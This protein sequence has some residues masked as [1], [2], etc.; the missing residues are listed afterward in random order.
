MFF[1]RFRINFFISLTLSHSA[2]SFI[3]F[4]FFYIV[5]G[6][7]SRVYT[8]QFWLVIGIYTYEYVRLDFDVAKGHTYTHT[9]TRITKNNNNRERT[10]GP[11]EARIPPRTY[12]Y[13]IDGILQKKNLMLKNRSAKVE[14]KLLQC[15][16]DVIVFIVYTHNQFSFL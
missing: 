5:C 4:F 2:G 16:S 3:V 7:F 10:K 1:K 14:R 13:T 15:R 12:T 8:G 11:K 9:H 6:F